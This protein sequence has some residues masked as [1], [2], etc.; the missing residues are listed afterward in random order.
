[1][2]ASAFLIR[3]RFWFAAVAIAAASLALS[4]RQ[5]PAAITFDGW[6]LETAAGRTPLPESLTAGLGA[7]PVSIDRSATLADGRTV[8]VVARTT[9]GRTTID[10]TATPS[11]GIR[12][13]GTSIGAVADEYFTGIMER[14]VDGPQ[15]ASWAP[16]QHGSAESAR[17]ER[18]T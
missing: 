9:G 2:I 1:M 13:W 12:R 6:F 14:V 8:R 15:Q 18:S 10:L 5:A 4:A 17:P 7:A 3:H 11:T 16:G